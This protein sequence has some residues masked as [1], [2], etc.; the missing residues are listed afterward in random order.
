V[1][2]KRRRGAGARPSRF[3]HRPGARGQR[4]EAASDIEDLLERVGEESRLGDACASAGRRLFLLR[5]AKY[6]DDMS[7]AADNA[8]RCRAPRR[9]CRRCECELAGRR[10]GCP[11]SARCSYPVRLSRTADEVIRLVIDALRRLCSIAIRAAPRNPAEQRVVAGDQ[12]KT[13]S[14]AGTSTLLTRASG[15]VTCVLR[16]TTGR[17]R[18]SEIYDEIKTLRQECLPANGRRQ[19]RKATH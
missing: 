11:Q 6:T 5:H 19:S 14:S 17:S 18:G 9:H 2:A 3:L 12:R 13:S 16:A 8:P 7:K 10:A 4:R 1:R 15:E